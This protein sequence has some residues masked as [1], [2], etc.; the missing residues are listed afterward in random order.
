M[1]AFSHNDERGANEY[2]LVLMILSRKCLEVIMSS[3]PENVSSMHHLG[4]QSSQQ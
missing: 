2:K 3:S 1:S 4:V